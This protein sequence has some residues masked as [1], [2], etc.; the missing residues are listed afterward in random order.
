MTPNPLLY[1]LLVVALVLICL[2]IHIGLPD[3][4]LSMPT[5]PRI[6]QAPTPTLQRA[7]ALSRAHPQTA[8]RDL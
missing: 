1:Q 5:A 8:L 4:P 2:L 3:K 7:Q 6:Q